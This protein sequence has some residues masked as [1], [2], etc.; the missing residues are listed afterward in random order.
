MTV[1]WVSDVDHRRHFT[2]EATAAEPAVPYGGPERRR[3]T[4]RKI[5][6]RRGEV[7]RGRRYRLSDRRAAR[8]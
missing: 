7:C 3:I 2:G 4:R 1:C 8:R 5:A 6:E